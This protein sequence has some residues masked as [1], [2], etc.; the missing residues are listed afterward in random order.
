MATSAN[1]IVKLAFQ[2]E[3]SERYRKTKGFFYNLL[4]NPQSA[5]RPYFDSFMILLVLASVFILIIEVQDDLGLFG[6]LFEGVVVTL[7]I[8]E[9]L[10]RFWLY[11]DV[12]QTV[13]EFHERSEFLNTRLSLWAIIKVVCKKKWEYMT[14]PMAIIDLLAIIPSYRPLRFLRIFLLFRLFKLFR[15]TRSISEFLKVLAEK[16]TELMTLAIFLGFLLFISATTLYFFE[17]D[18]PGGDIDSFFDGIYLSL[19]TLATVGYGDLTPHSTEGRIVTMVLIVVGLGLISFFTSIIVSAFNENM[20][21][22]QAQRVFSEVERKQHQIIICGYGRVG[23][24]VAELLAKEQERFVII[25]PVLEHIRLARRKGYLAVQGKAES[26]ELLESVGIRTIAK[27]ILCLT[28]DDVVNLYITLSARQLNPSIE[29]IS[30]ANRGENVAKLLRAGASHAVAPYQ[31][32]AR[33]S[34]AYVGQPVAFEA[35][36]D[37]T[38]GGKE[39]GMEMVRVNARSQFVGMSIGEI[40]FHQRRMILFGVVRGEGAEEVGSSTI[41]KLK[42][43]HFYFNPG[44]GFLLR[45]GD[46]MVLFGHRYSTNHLRSLLARGEL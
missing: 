26:D 39:V 27:R 34:A 11:N 18:T 8:I 7:F 1:A 38:S 2:L 14:S 17:V 31:V 25:D 41:Y 40:D 20:H 35:V 16:R 33:I 43:Q 23:Q 36:Y 10:L 44:E 29:I 45:S 12:H 28:S 46:M 4:E 6:D 3:R 24:E 19:V 21:D 32:V 42:E 30:R 13:L 5:V 15:Y 37:I 9:Y 22:I